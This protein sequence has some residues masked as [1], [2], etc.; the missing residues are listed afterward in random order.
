MGFFLFIV[1]FLFF[2]DVNCKVL[3]FVNFWDLLLVLEIEY[4]GI[5]SSLYVV[6]VKYLYSILI[7]M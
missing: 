4:D 1:S 7:N 3:N 5:V 6:F 2:I